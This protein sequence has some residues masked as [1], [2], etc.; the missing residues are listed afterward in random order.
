MNKDIRDFE[1]KDENDFQNQKADQIVNRTEGRLSACNNQIDDE[2][3]NHRDDQHAIVPPNRTNADGTLRTVRTVRRL[4]GLEAA[5]INRR[6]IIQDPEQNR[7][8]DDGVE[9]HL[10]REHAL[11]KA[12]AESNRRDHKCD[13]EIKR[14]QGC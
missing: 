12:H 5:F 11:A 6:D 2:K 7:C 10:L 13:D 8:G 3:Q 9:D 1:G 4:I 14:D